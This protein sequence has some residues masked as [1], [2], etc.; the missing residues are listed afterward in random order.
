MDFGSKLG[1]SDKNSV[2]PRTTSQRMAL[3]AIKNKTEVAEGS[4]VLE[5]QNY[6]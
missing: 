2:T 3:R 6:S 5:D 1:S 4:A